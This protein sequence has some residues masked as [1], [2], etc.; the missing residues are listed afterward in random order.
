MAAACHDRTPTFF[1]KAL[2]EAFDAKAIT[3]A[4]LTVWQ[5]D[6]LH[7][8]ILEREVRR[9]AMRARMRTVRNK[10]LLVAATNG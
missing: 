4:D 10:H 5:R 6:R 1:V 7:Q 2:L 3:S 9:E 8:L